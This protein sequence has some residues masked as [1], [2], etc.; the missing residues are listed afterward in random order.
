MLAGLILS[1]Y[2]KLDENPREPLIHQ[3]EQFD[4]EYGPPC[5]EMDGGCEKCEQ[6]CQ[7]FPDDC[8]CAIVQVSRDDCRYKLD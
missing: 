4:R 3:E 5:E 1:V 6:D 2:G 7:K 8:N